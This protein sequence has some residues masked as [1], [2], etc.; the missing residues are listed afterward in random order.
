MKNKII[1]YIYIYNIYIYIYIYIYS[2]YLYLYLVIYIE[3][4][5]YIFVCKI[6]KQRQGRQAGGWKVGNFPGLCS[7]TDISFY[8]I[9]L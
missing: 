8:S 9:Y 4:G 6:F 1:I 5:Y 7:G 3:N 2:F